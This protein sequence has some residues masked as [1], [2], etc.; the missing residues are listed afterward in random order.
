MPLKDRFRRAV[1]RSDRSSSN[2]S[3]STANPTTQSSAAP[4]VT[5]LTQTPTATVTP[6]APA[7]TLTKTSSRLSKTLTW[8]SKTDKAAKLE[9]KQRKRIEKWEKED[10]EAWVEPKTRYPGRK[11]KQHQDL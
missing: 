8:G 6:N 11:S 9:A 3:I 7:I 2:S 1:G 10:E 5:N 4:S